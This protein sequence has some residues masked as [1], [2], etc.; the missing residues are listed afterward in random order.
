[1]EIDGALQFYSTH[2]FMEALRIESAADCDWRA[3]GSVSIR[4]PGGGWSR[5]DLVG[6]C[7]GCGEVIFESEE[8]LG[9]LCLPLESMMGPALSVLEVR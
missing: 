4:D 2:W 1:M 8:S 9:E 6:D 3:S 5:L 7:S